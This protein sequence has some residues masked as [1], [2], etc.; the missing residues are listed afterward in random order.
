M[1]SPCEHG[2]FNL[3]KIVNEHN[4]PIMV[5]GR[6]G[7][8]EE[9]P[10]ASDIVN[11]TGIASKSENGHSNSLT[12]EPTTSTSSQNNNP[13]Q[14]QASS[15]ND[16]PSDVTDVYNFSENFEPPPFPDG[17][18]LSQRMIMIQKTSK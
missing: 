9:V 8:T 6:I 17:F 14:A 4:E 18:A 11:D 10:T 16:S 12:V 13:S 2:A 3:Y 5:F 1:D 15:S 7:N